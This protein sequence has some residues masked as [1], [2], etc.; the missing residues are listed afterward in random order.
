MLAQQEGYT[1]SDENAIRDQ[2]LTQAREEISRLK[3]RLADERFAEELKDALTSAVSA[4]AIASPVEHSR[5]LE[6]IVETASGV[7]PSRSAALFLID[8]RTEELV[9][10]VALG[11]EAEQVRDLRVPLGHG[12]AGLVAVSGQPM[13]VSDAA[14]DP[15]QAA[16]IAQSVGYA[17]GTVLCVPLFYDEEV[18]GVLELLDREGAASYGTQ[19]I[20]TL[21]LFA[22]QAAVA[23][24][25]SRA[26][27]SA[28]A[29][30][31]EA[32]SSSDGTGQ[33][34]LGSRTVEER[35]EEFAA[36][37]E[38]DPSHLG[39]LEL[40]RLVGEISRRGEREAEACRTILEGFADYLR[41]RPEDA[42]DL[43]EDFG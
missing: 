34:L 36:G 33:N 5:L 43:A 17:P 6:M 21:G 26:Q 14:E 20:A 13:A 27:G 15:R 37:I 31:R 38:R 40:A 9:F 7:I 2:E 25:Q 23:I 29:L 30:L 32:L 11:P 22:N 41:S 10:Q 18:M 12:I 4:G 24:E 8:E 16:D 19:D 35:V 28:A 42:G 3:R 1:A 39:A